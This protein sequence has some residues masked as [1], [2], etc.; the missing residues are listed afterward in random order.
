MRFLCSEPLSVQFS[1]WYKGE[2][3]LPKDSDN[4]HQVV[5]FNWVNS[6]IGGA[7]VDNLVSDVTTV[8]VPVSG[9]Y[10]LHLGCDVINNSGTVW[11]SCNSRRVNMNMTIVQTVPPSLVPKPK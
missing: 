4:Q 2:L 11:L 10:L 7:L 8:E 5:P 3:S 6:N 9:H 1:L